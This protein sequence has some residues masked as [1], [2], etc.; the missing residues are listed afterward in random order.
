MKAEVNSLELQQLKDRC[1]A[2]EL[3]F[4]QH[5][6]RNKVFDYIDD[7]LS[8]FIISTKHTESLF[9]EAI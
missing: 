6:G 1:Y 9:S 7:R 2:L 5:K 8:N 4:D 3:V